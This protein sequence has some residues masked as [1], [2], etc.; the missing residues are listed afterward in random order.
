[1]WG[2]LFV[3]SKELPGSINGSGLRVSYRVPQEGIYLYTHIYI[4]ADIQLPDPK[5]YSF[6]K[7]CLKAC[8]S[9]GQRHRTT[10]SALYSPIG[11][12][13]HIES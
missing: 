12:I 1:M 11:P 8:H 4:Y 10:L 3:P 6:G 7:R 13:I 2:S 5:P 9:S